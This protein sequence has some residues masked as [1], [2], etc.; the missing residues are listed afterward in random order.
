MT[1]QIF[2]RWSLLFLFESHDFVTSSM[3][4]TRR[5]WHNDL[6]H[7]WTVS[8]VI[9]EN[10]N[11]IYYRTNIHWDIVEIWQIIRCSLMNSLLHNYY[12]Y[13]LHLNM[14]VYVCMCVF[15]VCKYVHILYIYVFICKS[16][17]PIEADNRCLTLI[18]KDTLKFWKTFVYRFLLV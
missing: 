5:F 13:S 14:C 18:Y 2:F 12:Y 4:I 6:R 17:L 15:N 10:Y 7:V 3:T 9:D 11:P 1:L 8:N 16:I